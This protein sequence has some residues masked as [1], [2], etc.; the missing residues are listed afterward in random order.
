[1]LVNND[2]PDPVVQMEYY[3]AAFADFIRDTGVVIG[4]TRMGVKDNASIMDYQTRLFEREQVFPVFEVDGRSC[5][6]VRI[7]VNALLAVLEN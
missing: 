1:M 5:D 2:H 4:I 3:L 7:L 6:D